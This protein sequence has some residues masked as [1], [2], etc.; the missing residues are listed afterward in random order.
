MIRNAV[1]LLVFIFPPVLTAQPAATGEI[2]R[3]IQPTQK[4]TADP[5][6]NNSCQAVHTYE[7]T[8]DPKTNWLRAISRSIT[9]APKTKKHFL[10][11]LNSA[12]LEP[13]PY[14]SEA[15]ATCVDCASEP[16]CS[17]TRIVFHIQMKVFY[18]ASDLEKWDIANYVPGEVLVT[19]RGTKKEIESEIRRLEKVHKV[20]RKEVV[21]L[22]AI[23]EVLV[24]FAIVGPGRLVPTVIG[25]MQRDPSVL[26]IQPNF[27]YTEQHVQSQ[28]YES[29]QY[30]PKLI[31]ADHVSRY[32]TGK[33]IRIALIDT[34][35]AENQDL[36]GKILE[37]KNF[38]NDGDYRR[39]IHGTS[40]AGIIAAIPNNG[41]GINGVAPNVGI[42]SI[43]VLKS[44][45][46]SRKTYGLAADVQKGVNYAI[47]MNVN[48]ANMSIGVP[49][50][51]VGVSRLVG[52]AVAR[53]MVV[54]AAAGE[55]DP[56]GR[57]IYPAALSEVIAV[58]A[59]GEDMKPYASGSMGDYIDLAAPGVG[60]LSTQ[61]GNSYRDSNGTSEAAAHVTGVVA[62]LLEKKPNAS[63][64]QIQD[65][66]E[67]TSLDL[68]K[69]G[70]D[71]IFGSGLV[72]ACKAL[73]TL[74]GA[75]KICPPR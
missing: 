54:V 45:P 53:G 9:V 41:V 50:R 16:G 57:P 34:G 18:S 43:K 72:D 10:V 6:I 23:S 38:T 71:S 42:I 55:R 48:I 46:G 1:F 56:R 11:E 69:K 73:E 19:L 26:S 27:I 24:V 40:M 59:L 4:I 49:E 64:A 21:T 65:L 20:K 44:K 25:S 62:L 68:G 74:L 58:S 32:T 31:R 7:L 15:T 17:P 63:P 14:V 47:Q 66:L 52:V 22:S 2:Y 3:Q 29:L 35:V 60:I 8:V 39:D 28:D 61:P 5:G 67:R 12:G 36:E 33:G 75:G 13:G 51:D 70:K 37:R 30:G